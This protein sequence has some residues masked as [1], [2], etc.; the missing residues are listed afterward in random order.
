MV[1]DVARRAP[2]IFISYAQQDEALVRSLAQALKERG[3]DAWWAGRIEPGENWASASARA[4]DQADALVWLF[5]PEWATSPFAKREVEF[6]LAGSRFEQRVFPIVV[7]PG[8]D[9]P[10]SLQPHRLADLSRSKPT[11]DQIDHLAGAIAQK[12]GQ[13]SANLVS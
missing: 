5:S 12:L 6:A 1:G 8:I 9:L 2:R 3:L 11:S 4:L 10:W 13:T 7:R